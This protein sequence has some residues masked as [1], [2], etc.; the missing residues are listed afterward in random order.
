MKKF[1]FISFIIFAACPL[2]AEISPSPKIIYQFNFQTSAPLAI[3][4]DDSEELQCEDNQCIN[5]APL[6]K[7][8]I[9]KL[10][11]TQQSCFA[12]AY[13]FEPYQK[14]IIGF[15]DGKK[16]Q[17]QIF[18]TPQ[19]TRSTVQI[20]VNADDMQAIPLQVAPKADHF[21]RTYMLVSLAVT[22]T[23]EILAGILYLISGGLS[24]TI[25]L[26]LFAANMITIPFT[27]WILSDVIANT[28]IL[29][30]L[31]FLFETFFVY[32]TAGRR[33]ISLKDSCGL[34]FMT[35]VTGYAFGLI[36]VLIIASI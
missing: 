3:N 16:R 1:L 7:Y 9:Q 25:L 21:S 27:W 36:I 15:S 32:F 13:K 29:W 28:A 5:S 33:R 18:K 2:F 12:Y 35:N 8:G 22:V 19:A 11:C 30:I 14:L 17:T 10:Y 6:A 34:A 24:L 4:P 26:Y 20:N 23:L 31:K